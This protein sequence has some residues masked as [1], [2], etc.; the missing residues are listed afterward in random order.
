MVISLFKKKNK[1]EEDF[2]GDL[3]NLKNQLGGMGG[4]SADMGNNYNILGTGQNL[5]DYNNNP[6]SFGVLGNQNQQPT[7]G[8]QGFGQQPQFSGMGQ[9]NMSGVQNINNQQFGGFGNQQSMLGSQGLSQKLSL[10]ENKPLLKEKVKEGVH[11][12][13]LKEEKPLEVRKELLIKIEDY[14][15]VRELLQQLKEKMSEV[16]KIVSE[17]KE[18]ENKRLESIKGLKEKL[19]ESKSNI[20]SVLDIFR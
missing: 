18:D 7:F 16:E 14:K 19:E 6:G 11:K 8:S 9:Q 15:R 17:L 5:Y 20:N 4:M 10:E 13:H 3:D 12:K 2:Y 1:N